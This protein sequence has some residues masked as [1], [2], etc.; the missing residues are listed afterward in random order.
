MEIKYFPYQPH[1]FA[2]GGFDMQMINTLDSVIKAGVDASK[3]DI[4]S[5]NNDFDII[6]LWGVSPHN[7]HV[8]DWAK[9]S[10]KF[11][12]AT[13]LIPYF[14]TIR[15]KLSYLKHYNSYWQKHLIHYYSM[16]DKVVVVNELQ[17]FVLSKYYKVHPSKIAVIPHIIED[18]FFEIPSFSFSEKYDIDDYVL[19]TGNI[20]SRKN[21]LNLAKACINLDR[22][23]VLVGG[24]M[25]GEELYAKEFEV[26][27]SYHINI[28]W[29]KELPKGSEELAAAYYNCS[30]FALPSKNETQ[31]I[32]AL[33]AAA[34]NKPL[35][36]CER[37]YARQDYYQ[38]AI[39]T[40]STNVKDI[41]TALM[42]AL[43][44]KTTFK[45]NQKL[46]DCTTEAV[47]KAYKKVYKELIA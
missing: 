30:L 41:E 26:L 40:K 32:S 11:I 15:L 8:I 21:Q 38:G 1:C 39:L 12:I 36:L 2:F 42:T 16:I 31:P 17:A 9:K 46:F 7:Y 23:L 43:S 45:K 5:R 3:L 14:D 25:D 33:E 44:N 18:R 24:V 6:H 35:V 37:D 34:M 27:I 29:I 28:R 19:C 22:K 4:W 47:G 20:C 10:G 13:V